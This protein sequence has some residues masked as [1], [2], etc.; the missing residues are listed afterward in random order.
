MQTRGETLKKSPESMWR[1]CTDMNESRHTTR[2]DAVLCYARSIYGRESL[3]LKT[4]AD[5]W[6][7]KEAV[8]RPRK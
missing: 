3:Q 2:Q 7:T 8:R 1:T 5:Y 6:C 4:H